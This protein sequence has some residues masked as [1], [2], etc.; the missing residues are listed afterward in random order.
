MWGGRS[1]NKQKRKRI[2]LVT[3]YGLCLGGTK[4][5][6]RKGIPVGVVDLGLGA[7]ELLFAGLVGVVAT[8]LV[9]VFFGLQEREEV[10]TA[11]DLLA[12]ELTVKESVLNFWN[13]GATVYMEDIVCRGAR[14]TRGENGWN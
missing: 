7:K 6:G 8:G 2:T 13:G 11:P 10:Q 5:R 3:G 1:W 9:A 4:R 14:W 12:A